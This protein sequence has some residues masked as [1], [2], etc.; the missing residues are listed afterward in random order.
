MIEREIESYVFGSPVY[1]D[2]ASET[3]HY[4]DGEP[5]PETPAEYRVCPQCYQLPTPEGHDACLGTIPNAVAACCG[6]GVTDGYIAWKSSDVV[7]IEMSCPRWL[8]WFMRLLIQGINING[9]KPIDIGI[10]YYYNADDVEGQALS[11]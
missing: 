5:V 6:H 9:Q 3:F 2:D 1:F 7:Q 8:H 10:R 4:M 11:R